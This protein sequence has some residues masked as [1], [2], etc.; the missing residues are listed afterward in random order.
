MSLED[1]LKKMDDEFDEFM[2]AMQTVIKVHVGQ[3]LTEQDVIDITRTFN[4]LDKQ[5]E[6]AVDAYHEGV[7]EGRREAGEASVPDLLAKIE[8]LHT[9]VSFQKFMR[10]MAEAKVPG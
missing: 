2:D 6:R 9:E 7:K 8:E 3:V 1:D 10:K 4:E 5:G